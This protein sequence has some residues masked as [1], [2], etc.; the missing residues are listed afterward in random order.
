MKQQLNLTKIEK[1]INSLELGKEE[2]EE[3]WLVVGEI[4][5]HR[6]TGCL[7][8]NLEKERH[9]EFLGKFSGTSLDE[10]V[11]DYFKTKG[12]EDITERVRETIFEIENEILSDLSKIS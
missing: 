4:V 8:D 10:G 3:L 1:L 11:M 5:H 9:E 7:L 6:V 12:K 2:K